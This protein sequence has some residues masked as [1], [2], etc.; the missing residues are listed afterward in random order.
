MKELLYILSDSVALIIQHEKRMRKIVL[1]SVAS[2][3][4]PRF[5]TFSHKT[6]D[7]RNK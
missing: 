3:T 4:V 1:L 2:L 5:S 7:F 6:H